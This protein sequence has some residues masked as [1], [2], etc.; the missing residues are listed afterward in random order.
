M[1]NQI[2][3]QG[4]FDHINNFDLVRLIAAMQVVVVHTINHFELKLPFH[5]ATME[6]LTA[7]P[8]VPIFFVVS[9]FLIT[10]SYL[11]SAS[12]FDYLRNRVLRLVPA[13]WLVFIVGALLASL[14]GYFSENSV[15]WSQLLIWAVAQM[16]FVQ[17]YNPDFMRD[18]GVGVLNGSL[19]TLPV[20]MQFY[21]L[22]PFLA[23]LWSRGRW[24]KVALLS[25][26]IIFVIA[27]V[28]L[29]ELRSEYHDASNLTK[30]FTVSFV[31]WFYMFMLGAWASV[32]WSKL[33]AFL[34][35]KFLYW[36]LIY[37]VILL[38]NNF[39]PLGM[40]GNHILPQWAVILSGLTLSAAFTK[41]K[42]AHTLL[43][44][45]D[46]SYGMYI[47]HMPVINVI[48]EL[49]WGRP[50]YMFWIVVA[51]TTLLAW[52]SW[53]YVEKPALRLKHHTLL[54]R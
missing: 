26:F 50:H 41:P 35:G 24:K 12:L 3:G 40:T 38:V 34:E 36:L 45:N 44:R 9:G 42:L 52:L 48:L 22:T 1:N 47:F 14:T 46:I 31:P 18:Y 17:F 15:S 21:A 13:L 51:M 11:R 30:L 27:N 39:F 19:W 23:A 16:T 20:E 53:R 4:G 54:S 7:F 5:D 25:S 28:F 33:S 2:L 32:Y 49:G 37:A 43:N 29:R 10:T 8:G 6:V